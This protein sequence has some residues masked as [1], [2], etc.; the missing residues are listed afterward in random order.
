[1]DAEQRRQSM[2]ALIGRTPLV[3][4]GTLDR[5]GAPRIKVVS[6]NRREGLTSF[7]F[8]TQTERRTTADIQ[9]DNRASLYF[10]DNMAFE[11]L[12]LTGRARVSREPALLQAMWVEPMRGMFP[13]G[14]EDP[15]FCAIAFTAEGGKYYRWPFTGDFALAEEQPLWLNWVN[16]ET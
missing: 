8:V 7:W 3:Y 11:T 1:M 12:L 2:D 14:P 9:M 16:H 15:N 13:G 5:E 10:A 6:T 4:L